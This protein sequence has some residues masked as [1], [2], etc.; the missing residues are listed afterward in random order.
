MSR[1]YD[2]AISPFG[3]VFTNERFSN[4]SSN[5]DVEF[6]KLSSDCFCGNRF[7]KMKDEFC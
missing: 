3:I 5:V 2:H 1:F 6:V 7:S 4:C